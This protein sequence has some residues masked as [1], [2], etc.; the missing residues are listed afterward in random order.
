M[1]G[2]NDRMTDDSLIPEQRDDP[3]D[4]AEAAERERRLQVWLAGLQTGGPPLAETVSKWREGKAL[5]ESLAGQH[6]AE[7]PPLDPPLNPPF[8][9]TLVGVR[10]RMRERRER[11]GKPPTQI[12]REES[13]TRLRC[14]I[15]SLRA[16]R[17]AGKEPSPLHLVLAA[18]YIEGEM[19]LPQYTQAVLRL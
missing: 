2:N 9:E 11:D 12:T 8:E 7:D 19:D 13:E 16:D 14:V 1:L 6:V 4:S 3:E 15:E 18:R 10:R 17:A 5:H